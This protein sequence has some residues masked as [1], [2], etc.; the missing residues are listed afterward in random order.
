MMLAVVSFPYFEALQ[1]VRS[2]CYYFRSTIINN[3]SFY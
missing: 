1:A 2:I 3:K